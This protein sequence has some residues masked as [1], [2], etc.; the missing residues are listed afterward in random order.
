MGPLGLT[1]EFGKVDIV[2]DRLGWGLKVKRGLMFGFLGRLTGAI[3]GLLEGR[4]LRFAG[5]E[6][7]WKRR[8]QKGGNSGA[9]S[10]NKLAE[11]KA[12][13]LNEFVQKHA[14]GSVIEFGCGD[15]NQLAYARYPRYLGLDVS[16]D[17]LSVCRLKHGSDLTKSFKLVSEYKGEQ[18]DLV[19]SLDVVYHLVEDAVFEKYMRQLFGASR[20]FV[21]I[22]S[23]NTEKSAL[24][25]SP[26]V[27]HR[28][29]TV[30]VEKFMPDWR[31]IMHIPNKYPYR[32]NTE[33]G[34][35]ADFYVFEKT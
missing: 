30:W 31:L 3:Q 25:Q 4:L 34:S 22:Y 24:L 14:I 29:F 33:M 7:Y 20:N 26:H 27:R 13:F 19:L 23:T 1:V 11:F 16:P 8:Y 21:I 5:S 35:D 6:E 9:G 28:A 2:H 17:A 32:G 10:Y 15:G 12:D 18:A